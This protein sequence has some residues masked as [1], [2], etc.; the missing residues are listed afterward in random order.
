MKKK[1]KWRV[2]SE[3]F[4][5]GKKYVRITNDDDVVADY[6]PENDLP[7]YN[8]KIKGGILKCLKKR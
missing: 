8:L 1:L 4:F 2:I 7:K 6:I 3:H 5:R